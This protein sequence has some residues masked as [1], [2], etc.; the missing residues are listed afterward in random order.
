M[1]SQFVVFDAADIAAGP[2]CRV[3]LPRA[4]SFG[5]HGTFVPDLIFQA[6]EL[7]RRWKVAL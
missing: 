5:L 7:L 4:L 6:D 1:T 3:D 2:V